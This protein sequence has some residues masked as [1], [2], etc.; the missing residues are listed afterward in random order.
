MPN[1]TTTLAHLLNTENMNSKIVEELR[2]HERLYPYLFHTPSN[3]IT[4]NLN[5]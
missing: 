4:I 3:R 2:E 1:E 5:K